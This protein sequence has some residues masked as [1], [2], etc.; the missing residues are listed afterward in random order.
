M[1]KKIDYQLN[2]SDLSTIR[3]A[4]VSDRRPEVRQRSSALHMLHQGKTPG[5]VAELL[6][7]SL[8]S[9]Y[10][11]HTRW[12][13]GGLDGLANEPKSGRRPH[14]NAAYR[15]RLAEVLEME[16]AEL[17]YDFTMWTS[18]R[19]AAHMEEETGITLSLG[20]FRILLRQLG[21]VYRRPKHDLKN[22]QDA[23]AR[24]QAEAWLDDLKKKPSPER[25]TS[26]LWTRPLSDS[27]PS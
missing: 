9:V 13:E 20:R 5:E 24:T 12:R 1:P 15:E 23:E 10:K 26:S 19:L 25:S 6:A 14:A 2:E 3:K 21:Y 7:V 22:L 11:W 8:G 16:P 27:T 18:S 17:G 4:M